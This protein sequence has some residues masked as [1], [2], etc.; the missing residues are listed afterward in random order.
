M[1]ES[2]ETTGFKEHFVRK[3]DGRGGWMLVPAEYRML[4]SRCDGNLMPYGVAQM[5][6]GAVILV[7]GMQDKGEYACVAFVSADGG[8]SWGEAIPTGAYGRPLTFGFL[9]GGSV[10]F[11]NELLGKPPDERKKA[12]LYFSHD[13]GR[14]WEGV[15]YPLVASNGTSVV[16]TEGQIFAERVGSTTRLRHLTVHAPA[17][18]WATSPFELFLRSST[19]GGRT[20]ADERLMKEWRYGV[21]RERGTVE[22]GTSEGSIIRAKNGT[23]VAAVR[24]DM[25]PRYWDQPHDDS[26]E[27]LGVSRT[28]RTAR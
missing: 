12:L 16:T 25:H 14:S 8:S 21:E 3:G 24:T 13:H 2:K 1:M 9:G 11:G 20:W 4:T 17:S 27:G 5:D 15:P 18:N 10:V 23:L 22:R 19:D 6:N 28:G 7:A 26:L